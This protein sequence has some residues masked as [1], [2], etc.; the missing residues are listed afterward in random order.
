MRERIGPRVEGLENV[1]ARAAN[2]TVFDGTRVSS[3]G[4][5]VA[6]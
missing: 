2:V 3:V 5:P 1:E 6:N 4:K